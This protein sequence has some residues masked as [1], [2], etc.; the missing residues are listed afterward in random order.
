MSQGVATCAVSGG[1]DGN[2]G[3]GKGPCH[4]YPHLTPECASAVTGDS[5]LYPDYVTPAQ[6]LQWRRAGAN[7]IM[8][9]L[10]ATG[11]HAELGLDEGQRLLQSARFNFCSLKILYWSKESCLLATLLADWWC[12]CNIKGPHRHSALGF[13]IPAP[14]MPRSQKCV[15]NTY[16]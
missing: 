2:G 4:T 11:S 7:S 5:S 1:K 14:C 8:V 12:L 6:R 3:H 10:G 9:R 13:Q 16:G 15:R